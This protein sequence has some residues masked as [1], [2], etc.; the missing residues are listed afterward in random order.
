MVFSPCGT[1]LASCSRDLQT[2]PSWGMVLEIIEN[3]DEDK[4]LSRNLFG[5]SD[6]ELPVCVMLIQI[7]SI[8]NADFLI[9][10]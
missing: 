8:L 5:T 2:V 10:M 3:R 4:A 6:M 7:F 1:R 9:I